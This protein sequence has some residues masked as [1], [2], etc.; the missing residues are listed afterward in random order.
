MK[1]HTIAALLVAGTFSSVTPAF[2]A[3]ADQGQGQAVITVMPK[4]NE[5]AGI[6]IQP[7]NLQLKVDGKQSNVT[8]FA[9]SKGP[10]SPLELVILIDSSARTSLGTQLS[11]IEGFVKEMPNNT[12][13]A[14]AYM[15][16]GRAALTGPLSSDPSQVLNGLHLPGGAAGVSSSPYFCLSD[17]AK[18]WPSRDATARREVL[19]ITDGIDYYNV[20]LDPE[21]PYVQAAI[22]DSVRSGL[23]V[24]S[25]YW[26]NRGG[27][28]RS[29][30]ASDAGQSL[31]SEVTQATGGYSY[32]EGTGNP[33][34]FDPFFK[35]L[36]QRFLNQYRLSFSAPLKGKPQIERFSLKLQGPQAKVYAPQQ[37]LVNRAGTIAGE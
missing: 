21:D 20:R 27:L 2:A 15:E 10:N 29:A 23:V 24:Y 17:L 26:M 33:V 4:G 3:P 5:G 7:Q 11:D 19:M 32:W 16:N 31:L 6:N 25:F 9:P 34:S 36:R 13:I 37:V 22:E 14:I 30:I 12:R 35:D 8:N 1:S 28:D 18:N